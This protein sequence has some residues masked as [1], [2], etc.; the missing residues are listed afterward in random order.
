MLHD[1]RF[2]TTLRGRLPVRPL[3]L[4][5]FN[6]SKQIHHLLR[7]SR[8]VICP[9]SMISTGTNQA[10]QT[11]LAES[12][13]SRPATRLRTQNPLKDPPLLKNNLTIRMWLFDLSY[14]NQSY[15]SPLNDGAI[16]RTGSRLRV[17]EILTRGNQLLVPKKQVAL[18]K[19]NRNAPPIAAKNAVW[20]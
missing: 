2:L 9:V 7:F 15:S 4:F 10:G 13:Q 5:H 19:A 3:P 1:L 6:L 20:Q 8:P 16:L 18:P 12:R 17:S 11:I 14:V